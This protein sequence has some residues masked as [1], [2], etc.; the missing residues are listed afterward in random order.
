MASRW[1]VAGVVVLLSLLL[2]AARLWISRGA[3]YGLESWLTGLEIAGAF[4]LVGGVIMVAAIGGGA[5]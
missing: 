4:V 2:L 1:A 5:E 3:C